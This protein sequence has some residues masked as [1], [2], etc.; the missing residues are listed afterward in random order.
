MATKNT[1]TGVSVEEDTV[2]NEMAVLGPARE[3]MGFLESF[4]GRTTINATVDKV[5]KGRVQIVRDGRVMH[6][7]TFSREDNINE[8]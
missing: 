2:S 3:R 4:S 5:G 8:I 7:H 1:V 6:T